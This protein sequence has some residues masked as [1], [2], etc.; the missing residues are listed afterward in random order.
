MDSAEATP[1]CRE[2]SGSSTCCRSMSPAFI[3]GGWC[4]EGRAGRK[5]GRWAGSTSW[6]VVGPAVMF[7]P[8]DI[9]LVRADSAKRACD[10]HETVV[11][12]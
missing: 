7:S 4:E 12:R 1:A 2:R 10:G 3:F 5:V 6:S 11:R 8:G 9:T